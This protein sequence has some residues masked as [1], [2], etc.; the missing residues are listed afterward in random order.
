MAP[1]K[2]NNGKLLM[3]HSRD[4]AAKQWAE[5]QVLTLSGVAQIFSNKQATLLKL[6]K[7]YFIVIYYRF[8][9]FFLDIS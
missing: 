6:G 8:G 7:P 9:V 2:R 3:H 4:T 5:T 1:E